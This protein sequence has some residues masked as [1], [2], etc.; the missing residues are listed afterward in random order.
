MVWGRGEVKGPLYSESAIM[1]LWLFGKTTKEMFPSSKCLIQSQEEKQFQAI[2]NY[3]LPQ[4]LPFPSKISVIGRETD[5]PPV[6]IISF[7]TMSWAYT[8]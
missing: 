6:R 5:L 3:F 4:F 8:F 7:L 1:S 2:Y